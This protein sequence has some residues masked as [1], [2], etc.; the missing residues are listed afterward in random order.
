MEMQN[1]LSQVGTGCLDIQLC[2]PHI[3]ESAKGKDEVNALPK[4]I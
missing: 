2:L 1:V 4:T 3:L